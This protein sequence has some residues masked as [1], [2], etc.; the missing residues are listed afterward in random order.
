MTIQYTAD[1]LK[2][3][4]PEAS[5]SPGFARIGETL[6]LEGRLDEAIQTCQKGIESRPFQ[7]SGYLVLGKTYIDA[8]RLDEAREQFETVLRLDPRCLSALNLLA[9]IMKNQQWGDAAVGFYRAILAVEP[10]DH[11]IQNL[12][13]GVSSSV[14]QPGPS[15]V[16]SFVEE[17]FVKPPGL[18]GDVMDVNLSDVGD[19]LP[20]AES[21]MLTATSTDEFTLEE[22]LDLHVTAEPIATKTAYLPNPTFS[23][24]E[25]P[26][27][28]QDVEDRLDSL[29]GAEVVPSALQSAQAPLLE[30]SAATAMD[31]L[32][33]GDETSSQLA[34]AEAAALPEATA[35]EIEEVSLLGAI[36]EAPVL[37]SEEIVSGEDIENRLDQLF[38]LDL[39][40]PDPNLKS[41]E[42]TET[43]V[44]ER[45]SSQ[46]EQV[47]GGD[48][49]DKLDV[50]FGTEPKTEESLAASADSAVQPNPTWSPS[51]DF[52][53]GT[54]TAF[55]KSASWMP[56]ADAPEIPSGSMMST[57]SM[58][59]VGWLA[60]SGDQPR[61]TGAD[62]ESQL[63][64][65]F[66]MEGK[67]DEM[68]SE[69]KT[70]LSGAMDPVGD[71]L[72][73]DGLSDEDADRT[74]TLPIMK[75]SEVKD[76]V[77][78]WLVKQAEEGRRPME[79]SNEALTQDGDTLMMPTDELI[80]VEGMD[81][82]PDF[83]SMLEFPASNQSDLVEESQ[84]LANED[85]GNLSETTSIEMVDGNDITERLDEIFANDLAPANTEIDSFQFDD[86]ASQTGLVSDTGTVEAKASLEQVQQTPEPGAF[87]TGD[88]VSSRVS[89]IFDPFET[90]LNPETPTETGILPTPV[91]SAPILAPMLDEEDGYPEEEEMPAQDGVGANVATVTLA[92]IYF[93]QGLREQALQIYR[94][95]LERE[96]QNDSVR[97][98][99]TEIEA[100]KPDE[101]NRG[102]ETDP[103]RPRPGLKVPKRKK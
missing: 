27:S 66:D 4:Y 77:A 84:L 9:G 2:K 22:A 82:I 71:S 93:Q 30:D 19:F 11:E 100:S 63:D 91:I 80:D 52:S 3:R 102:A 73:S 68:G 26:I 8:G 44:L 43:D 31:M 72:L 10:W 46:E 85:L 89:E 65:L 33:V 48:I 34:M 16:P 61:I 32:R 28:G 17:T 97:T 40:L 98:R 103:R 58:L 78:D 20:S 29:F 36:T 99:I 101:E 14:P 90:A 83:D 45:A 47:T 25:P 13:R 96:P 41:A 51:A 81:E 57:E 6:R 1:Q 64:K 70:I 94:Q 54:E 49:A 79:V 15:H 60:D 38:S 55:I 37:S 53:T 5:G 75:D 87:V 39:K 7:L 88:D 12:L 92:E 74:M 24:D 50:L 42:P 18:E 56:E 23:P 95:L 76:G 86:S 67:S 69:E 62:I 35:P 21:D 59:P